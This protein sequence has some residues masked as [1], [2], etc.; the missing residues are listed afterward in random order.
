MLLLLPRVGNL[1]LWTPLYYSS[2]LLRPA[3]TLDLYKLNTTFSHWYNLHILFFRASSH[4]QG[5]TSGSRGATKPAW[6]F[7]IGSAKKK[8]TLIL[9]GLNLSCHCSCCFLTQFI[10]WVCNIGKP[11]NKVFVVNSE[12]HK[13]LHIC[14]CLGNCPVLCTAIFFLLLEKTLSC[15][16]VCPWEGAPFQSNSHFRKLKFSGSLD[17]IPG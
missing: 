17:L 1:P 5:L 7:K 15:Q 6:G 12:P 16:V 3:S 14:D 2:W 9:K 10:K 13:T 11:T 8:E 4:L